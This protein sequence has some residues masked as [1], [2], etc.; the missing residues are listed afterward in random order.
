MSYAQS[1]YTRLDH[2]WSATQILDHNG[3]PYPISL[4]D[5]WA[6]ARRLEDQSPLAAGILYRSTENVIGTGIDVRPMT[7]SP[8]FNREIGELWGEW[9]GGKLADVRRMYSF[10]Q[11][12]RLSYRAKK[13]DG[14][15]GFILIDRME[16]GY[17]WP[18]LQFVECDDIRTP[19]MA[20]NANLRRIVE[21]VEF[22]DS[23]APVAFW[24]DGVDGPRRV[25]A[26]DFVFM[27]NT[28]RAKVARGTSGFR[29]TYRL[30]D[31][32]EGHIE[33][34]VV[35]ARI[36][37]S[38]AMIGKRKRPEK[39]LERLRDKV[40]TTHTADGRPVAATIIEAGRINWID[41]DEELVGFNPTQPHQD[42][43]GFL[44]AIARF[45]GLKFGLTVERVLLDFSKANYSVSRS[46]ALQEQKAAEPEQQEFNA[47]FFARVYPWFVSKMV[48]RGRVKSKPPR[49]MW[50]YE[51]IPNGRPLVEPSK[52]APGLKTLIELGIEAPEY[53][54]AERGYDW[55][56]LLETLKR[57]KAE[58]EAVGLSLGGAS[59]AIEGKPDDDA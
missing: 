17:Q 47:D 3:V 13:R 42:F 39:H 28:Y 2:P 57:N 30:F 48:A 44:V 11:L 46:T 24:I 41:T 21:G 45:L 50:A 12:Q 16:Q 43:P 35:A 37:A 51:W 33:A 32:L 14:D 49:N 54:A 38:Q 10:G 23:L 6:R 8:E 9:T 1:I 34:V 7:D 29:G 5:E 27:L 19:T 36:A 18:E 4:H 56:K 58:L 25:L 59:K 52:E 53:L 26:R 20:S 15:C 31:Q 22:N 40:G 55:K